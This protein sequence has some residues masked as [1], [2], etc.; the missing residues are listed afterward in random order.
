MQI[1]A[2]NCKAQQLVVENAEVQRLGAESPGDEAGLHL[3][4]QTHFTT[5]IFCPAESHSSQGNTS[6]AGT[7]VDVTHP[8][9]CAAP[10]EAGTGLS[11]RST[12]FPPAHSSNGESPAGTNTPLINGNLVENPVAS[13][14]PCEE[15]RCALLLWFI[16]I[17]CTG[18]Y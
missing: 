9:G 17:V 3:L 18:I 12:A 1:K 8:M 14:R 11:P 16:L 13:K 4:N 6:S 15:L 2:A 5:L 10:S 7:H